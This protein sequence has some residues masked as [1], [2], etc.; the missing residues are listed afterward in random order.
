MQMS[1]MQYVAECEIEPLHSQLTKYQ[2]S[3]T[4]IIKVL[5]FNISKNTIIV[6]WPLHPPKKNRL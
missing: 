2:K 6:F 3:N 4:V 1:N 5:F